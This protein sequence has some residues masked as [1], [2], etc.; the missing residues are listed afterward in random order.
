[1][2]LVIKHR[3]F[4]KPKVETH[5]FYKVLE[6][7]DNHLYS[8]IVDGYRWEPGYNV[9]TSD[10]DPLKYVNIAG[11]KSRFIERGA[12]HCHVSYSKALQDLRFLKCC[13]APEDKLVIVEVAVDKKDVIAYGTNRDV[14]CRKVHLDGEMY[15]EALRSVRKFKQN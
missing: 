10:L 2:C 4:N 7:K 15:L 8:P 5:T 6:V 11:I 14:A 3:E 1:M 9:P 12:I 13:A